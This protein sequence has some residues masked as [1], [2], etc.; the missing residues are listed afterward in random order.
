[1][2]DDKI[3]YML[4]VCGRWR[5]RPTKTMRIPIPHFS[6]PTLRPIRDKMFGYTAILRLIA[7]SAAIGPSCVMFV[8]P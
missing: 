1:M 6:F 8:L 5:W 4:F 3:R 2:G 7:L